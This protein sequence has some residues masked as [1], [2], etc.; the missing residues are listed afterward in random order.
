MIAAGANQRNASPAEKIPRRVRSLP[1]RPPASP[2]EEAAL[3]D[4][5]FSDEITAD[6]QRVV[7]E[8]DLRPEPPVILDS[9]TLK[10]QL[11]RVLAM[12]FGPPVILLSSSLLFA[13]LEKNNECSGHP[14]SMEPFSEVWPENF[15]QLQNIMHVDLSVS[16]TSVVLW[17]F[18]F[19]GAVTYCSKRGV[20]RIPRNSV[21]A[22]AYMVLGS[23]SVIVLTAAV[24]AVCS[25][26]SCMQQA[27][28]TALA[29]AI[30]K[31]HP[32]HIAHLSD[33][34]IKISVLGLT[35]GAPPLQPLLMK[36]LM[37]AVP[38]GIRR[39]WQRYTAIQ[40]RNYELMRTVQQQQ[41][42]LHLVQSRVEEI[43]EELRQDVSSQQQRV[44][45]QTVLSLAD[46][47]LLDRHLRWFSNRG[48]PPFIQESQGQ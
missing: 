42:G 32:V 35:V 26:T 19:V 45:R 25:V 2:K 36:V 46:A 12:I 13:S 44:A 9:S 21:F 14:A 47:G 43:Q 3:A 23:V 28:A 29:V 1:A 40:Q 33:P 7:D 27:K 20:Q 41:W 5:L 10:A 24:F 16:W 15:R 4:W 11:R 22:F 39:L 31:G 30:E 18:L 17:G 8:I 37:T 6:I 38:F 34:R 48:L